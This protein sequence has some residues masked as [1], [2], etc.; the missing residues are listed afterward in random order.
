MLM[1]VRTIAHVPVCM[2]ILR[3]GSSVCMMHVINK[4]FSPDEG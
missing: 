4:F 1:G 2:R 3:L